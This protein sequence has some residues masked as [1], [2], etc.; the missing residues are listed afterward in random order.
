MP[1]V[2]P[3]AVRFYIP[4]LDGL[5]FLAFLGVFTGHAVPNTGGG[6][7]GVSLFFVLSSYLITTILVRELDAKGRI[8]V[9]AFWIRRALRIWPLY[10]GFLCGYAL[11]GGLKAD[12]F[13]AFAFFAGNW[14]IVSWGISSA[15]FA[16]VLWSVSVEEQFY[17][18]WPLVLSTLPRRFLRPA[19]VGFVVTAVAVR[20]ALYTTGAS[21][22]DVWPNTFAQLDTIG[23]GALIALGPKIHLTPAVRGALGAACVVGLTACAQAIFRVIEPTT[24]LKPG[25][26]GL[27]TLVFL[28]AS[29]ACGGLLLA[30]LAGSEWLSR[31]WITYLGR[32]SYGLYVFHMTAIWL[33]ASWAWPYRLTAAFAITLAFAAVSYRFLERPFLRL[34]TRY[35]YVTSEGRLPLPSE[36]SEMPSGHTRAHPNRRRAGLFTWKL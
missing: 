25:T 31:P 27:A 26:A 30:A 36:P 16:G 24:V 9:P 15:G 20:Y 32:I 35:T 21:V 19:C 2:T 10:F 13:T 34:K 18:V 6:G 4:Q 17:L 29:V 14:G 8:D 3:G 5:R 12:A 22:A 23:I 33:V 11:L 7:F 28:G 1:G